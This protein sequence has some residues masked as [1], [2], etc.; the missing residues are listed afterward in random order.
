MAVNV[1]EDNVDKIIEFAKGG[2]G[3]VEIL[4][5]WK[6]TPTYAV[7]PQLYPRGLEGLKACTD[8]IHAAGLQVGMHVMQGMVGWGGVGMRDPYVSPKADPRL[9]QERRATLAAEVAAD[10]TELAAA[11][12]LAEWPESGDVFI[13]GEL[14]R[15]ARRADD[16]FLECQ[17]GLHD[18]TVAA[19]AAGTPVGLLKNVFGM[20]GNVI[21]A[22][23]ANSDLVDEICDNI[24]EVFNAVD[25]DMSYFDAGEEIA[26]QPPSWRNQGRIA[27]GA[28][29]PAHG[30]ADRA[31]SFEHVARAGADEG[32]VAGTVG[33]ARVVAVGGDRADDQARVAGRQRGVVD[34]ELLGRPGP[35][36]LDH[37]VGLRRERLETGP[38]GRVGEVELRGALAPLPDPVARERA[39]RVAAGRFAFDDER[40]QIGEEAARVWAG[41]AGGEFENDDVIEGEPGH[42]RRDSEGREF[43]KPTGGGGGGKRGAAGERAFD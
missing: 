38:V 14:V 27:L 6:S 11:E 23:D 7:S 2:F 43:T 20:W 22:P 41:H 30:A 3:C 37:D 17:R 33:E 36:A 26:V 10:A 15:Y 1:T 31:P 13:D 39:E 12:S 9:F 18:T 4:N 35:E 8:K 29:E 40:A 42:R 28:G 32:V 16:R 34:A 25:A 24:A 5:W 19:H 21:Y